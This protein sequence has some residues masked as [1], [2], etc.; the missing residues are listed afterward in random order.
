MLLP[1]GLLIVAGF[2]VLAWLRRPDRLLSGSV[3]RRC[4]VTCKDGSAFQGVLYDT[5]R[6]SLVLRNAST[7][8]ERGQPAAVDGEVLVLRA[9]VAYL[10]LP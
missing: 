5:D 10:Q 4:L 3:K 2:A 6:V 1:V 8:D 9:D 7:L